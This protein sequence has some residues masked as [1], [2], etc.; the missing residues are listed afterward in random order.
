MQL[1]AFTPKNLFYTASAGSTQELFDLLKDHPTDLIEFFEAAS[2]DETWSEDHNDFMQKAI[3]WFT[4]VLFADK[5]PFSHGV[6]AAKSI[7]KHFRILNR[8]L[9]EDICIHLKDE[10]VQMNSLLLTTSSAFFREVIA[11]EC[12][13]KKKRELSFLTVDREVFGPLKTYI[14]T[15]QIQDVWK[16]TQEYIF[17]LLRQALAWH[18]KDAAEQCQQVLVKYITEDNVYDR[19]LMALQEHFDFIAEGAVNYINSLKNGVQLSIPSSE[20]LI[21]Q[22]ED[23]SDAALVCFE[24]LQ[25]HITELACTGKT[26]G[27]SSLPDLVVR[28]PHLQ[29]LDISG[30]TESVP[31]LFDLPKNLKGLN[32]S[33]SPWVHAETLVQLASL[34]PD[35][36][37]LD[38][39]RNYQLGFGAWGELIRF[40]KLKILNISYC[41]QIRNEDVAIILKAAHGLTELDIQG[42]IRIA[43]MGFLNIGKSLPYLAVLNVSRSN[44]T[45]AALIEIVTRCRDLVSIDISKCPHLTK[46][47]IQAIARSKKLTIIHDLQTNY[48]H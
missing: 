21:F 28:C 32:L 10:F 27:N 8:H 45:D 26:A 29:M 2:D 12:R 43:D 7:K 13:D 3:S 48:N 6:R 4:E 33:Q 16:A 42:C 35:L 41:H 31:S 5:I 44:I 20:Y 9:P 24:R 18:L 30:T 37:R 40:K 11:H 47:G 19:L 36:N 46:K 39:A 17:T 14:Y 22:F 34:Y 1:P 23:I 25:F 38:L 15:G